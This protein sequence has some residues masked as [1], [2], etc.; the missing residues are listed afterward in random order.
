MQDLLQ[1]Q[2]RYK[3]HI[4]FDSKSKLADITWFLMLPARFKSSEF[5]HVT[6]GRI[7]E[8]AILF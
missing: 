6:F 7:C 8:S 4:K 1:I 5:E 2:F 3:N